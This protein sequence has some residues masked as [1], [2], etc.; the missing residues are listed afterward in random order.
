MNSTPENEKSIREALRDSEVRYR[1]LFETAQDGILLLDAGTGRI[2]DSN[3]FLQDM[4][5]YTREQLLG[6]ELWEIGFFADRTLSAAAFEKLRKEGYIRYECLPLKSKDGRGHEV[7]FVS[8]AYEV[9][10]TKVIQCNVREI[11]ERQQAARELF[12][13]RE[14]LQH[15]IHNIP[16]H[17]FW[18][19]QNL[20]YLGAN[21]VFI[22]SAGLREPAEIVGKSDFDLSWKESAEM[23]RADDRAVIET[24]IPKLNYEETQKRPDGSV[25]WL[26]TSKV[27]LLDTAGKVIGILGI[28]EDITQHKQAEDAL[29]QS[30][31]SLAEAQ[32]ISHLGSWEWSILENRLHWSDEACRIV[33]L[34]PNTFDANFEGFLKIVHPADRAAV[35]KA[36]QESLVGNGPYNIEHRIVRPDGSERVVQEQGKVICDEAG[37]PIRMVGTTLDIT[38]RKLSNARIREQNEILSNSHEGVMIVNLA[39]KVTLWNRGAERLFG[40]TAAEALGFPPKQLLPVDDPAAF[41]AQRTAIEREGYWHG[42]LQTQTRDGRKLTVD[43][44]T[45]LVRDEAGQPRARISFFADVTEKKLLEEKFLRTQ[46]LEN[47]GMLAAGIAHD[48]NNVLTPILAIASLLRPRLSSAGEL[49]MLDTLEQSALRGAGLVKQILGFVRST[50]GTPQPTQVKH[51]ANDIIH[52]IEETFPK[53]IKLEYDISSDL[54]PVLCN[55]TQIHQV[56]LNL[57]INARDAMPKGGTLRMVAANRRLNIAEAAAIPAGRPGTWLMLEVAD[58]GTGTAPDVLKSI[59]TPFFTTKGTGGTGLGLST[60]RGIVASHDGFIDLHTG[61]A[62][63]SIFRVFLPAVEGGASRPGGTLPLGIPGGRGE[64]ILVVD[65]EASIRTIATA[66]LEEHGYGV[67]SCGDGMEAITIF[68]AH[69]GEIALVLTDVDMPNLNG[70]ELA[71]TLLRIR[72]DVRLIVMSGLSRSDAPSSDV[73]MARKL[74]HAFLAKPFHPDQ[75]LGAVHRVLNPAEKP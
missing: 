57:C 48:L 67:Q 30:E 63:G 15:V 47:I 19:D 37:R 44:H 46:Q 40:W 10:H 55:A 18:K 28:H 25:L 70:A 26:R 56:L 34:S 33:G 58:T 72:P 22:K 9:D 71:K 21:A 6:K 61:V 49:K 23:Y 24:G 32:H 5:G 73:T 29:R 20:N 35:E 62:Q 2:T 60:I 4:L 66:V 7:E 41:F 54:W 17:V 14:R 53:S 36:V 11:T 64:L 13:S 1:R 27:P 39:S 31:A 59:W 45:T 52:I 43:C 75:L 42:E 8:N 3:P 65:D 38:E 68:K 51:I 50:T 16:Q 74:A 69:S 12:E